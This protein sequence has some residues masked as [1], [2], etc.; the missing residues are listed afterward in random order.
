MRQTVIRLIPARL[1]PPLRR[2]SKLYQFLA[3]RLSVRMGWR[4]PLIPPCWLHSVGSP[5]FVAV[6]EDF[7]RYFVDR[8]GLEPHERVLDVGCGTGRLARPL[9]RYLQ[10]GSYEGIDIVAPSIRWCQE[11]YTPK[12]PRFHFHFANIYNKVYN[13]AGKYKAS[14]YSFPF[15]T[16]SFDFVF[17]TSVFTHML[18][19]D[20]ENYLAEVARVLK[21]NGRCLITYFLLNPDAWKLINEGL[22][23]HN[24]RYELPGCYVESADTPEAVVGYDESIIRGLYR[25]YGLNISEPILYGTWCQRAD[26]L[27]WQDMIIATKPR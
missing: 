27:S 11:T 15:E 1:R 6:G 21:S 13:P 20:V 4:D 9:T 19:P 10:S 3:Y 16:S 25:K 22:S 18:R 12:F 14:E 26:G 17:L 23:Y 8:C 24:F 2:L 7:L 5:D